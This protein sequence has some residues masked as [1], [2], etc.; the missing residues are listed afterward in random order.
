MKGSITASCGHVLGDDESGVDVI[1]SDE[2]CDAVEGFRPILVYAHFCQKCAD[3]WKL[4]G[5]LFSGHDEANAW[6]AA[7][8]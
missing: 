1:Y 5:L 7:A 3:E 4:K 6:L 2:D 8:A